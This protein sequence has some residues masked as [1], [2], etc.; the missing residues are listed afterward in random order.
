MAKFARVTDLDGK[1]HWVN[2]EHVRLLVEEPATA[3]RPARTTVHL[4]SSWVER[5]ITVVESPE[6]I[7]AA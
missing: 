5:V 2:L 7:T 4:D 6:Q 3:K 1:V